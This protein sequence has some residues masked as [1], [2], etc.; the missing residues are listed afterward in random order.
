MIDEVE[1]INQARRFA[2]YWV[3]A[4]RGYDT[5]SLN[6][7][8]ARIAATALVVAGLDEEAFEEHFVDLYVQLVS[9][10]E[11]TARPP[12]VIRPVSLPEGAMDTNVT[13]R[14]DVYLGI[15]DDALA[16]LAAAVTDPNAVAFLMDVRSG[17]VPADRSIA[18]VLGGLAERSDAL[19]ESLLDRPADSWIEAVSGIHVHWDDAT[20]QYHT[21]W[22]E[23]PAI[24]RDPDARI[25][26]MPYDVG[27]LETFHAQLVRVLCCQVRDVFLG[28][29]I[30]P[31]D[32]FRLQGHGIHEYTTWYE[33][34]DFYERYHDPDATIDT[35]YEDRTPDDAYERVGPVGVDGVS[36]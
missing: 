6:E 7:D 27:T 5:L 14:T 9:H 10:G 13:Y 35:W 3:H 29:G 30:A 12:A 17:D 23:Q 34:Y 15:D 2:K 16:A 19:D 31:P 32:A 25:D 24:D 21:E 8:P 4:K 20:G 26:V 33:H 28:M 22:G 36:P 1:P 18:S 11:D